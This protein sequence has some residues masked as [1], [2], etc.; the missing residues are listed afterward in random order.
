VKKKKKEKKKKRK[1][2]NKKIIPIK[3]PE[4][5]ELNSE[6]VGGSPSIDSIV[7]NIVYA[8]SLSA[9]CLKEEEKLKRDIENQIIPLNIEKILE[10]YKDAYNTVQIWNNQ[11]ESNHVP[12]YHANKKLTYIFT[13]FLNS[14]N[15]KIHIDSIKE[16]CD[17]YLYQTI[18]SM[19]NN[20]DKFR[21]IVRQISYS[22]KKF[23][24]HILNLINHNNRLLNKDCV[25]CID[26]SN[27]NMH[28]VCLELL[29]SILKTVPQDGFDRKYLACLKKDG[30]DEIYTNLMKCIPFESNTSQILPHTHS[31][32][33]IC[34]AFLTPSENNGLDTSQV[35]IN[36]EK[37]GNNVMPQP[38]KTPLWKIIWHKISEP[39]M[40]FLICFILI[41]VIILAVRQK[42][43]VRDLIGIILTLV[44]VLGTL[45]IGTF[46]D[47]RAE[48]SGSHHVKKEHMVMVR[49]NKGE[50]SQINADDLVVGDVVVGLKE[51]EN[52]PADG[53]VFNVNNFSTMEAMLTG[54]PIEVRKED[55]VLPRDTPLGNRKNMCFAS[56][57]V[58]SGTSDLIVCATGKNTECGSLTEI[59]E[60]TRK[61]NENKKTPL[62]ISIA[63]LSYVLIGLAIIFCCA[64][65]FIGIGLEYPNIEIFEISLSLAASAV[66][67]GLPAILI[68]TITIVASVMKRANCEI[69][70]NSAV[71]TIGSVSRICSDKTGT[72]TVG[73]MSA[74]YED[75]VIVN[76][77]KTFE[78]NMACLFCNS[79]EESKLTGSEVVTEKDGDMTEIAIIQMIQ[80]QT[81]RPSHHYKRKFICPFDSN[82]KRMSCGIQLHDDDDNILVLA[83]GAPESILSFCSNA[84]ET[85]LKSSRNMA[86][87]GIRVLALAY[88]QMP[89]PKSVSDSN[90]L[91]NV[92]ESELIFL[93]L[94]GI[95]DP[96]KEGVK[97]T[98]NELHLAHIPVVMITGDHPDTGQAIAEQLDIFK[99]DENHTTMTGADFIAWNESY[100]NDQTS[101]KER[102]KL[103][104]KFKNV[105]VFA[106]VTP[107]EKRLIVQA[108]QKDRDIV[109]MLGDGPND[110][111]AI[112]EAD[113]GYAMFS[114]TDMAKDNA[115]VVILDNRLNS[116]TDSIRYGRSIFDN[117][118]KFI[119]YLISCNFAEVFV[120]LFFVCLDSKLPLTV[121]M[122]LWANIFADIPPSVA[123]SYELPHPDI[124]QRHP[125][126][127]DKKIVSWSLFIFIFLQS[128]LIS[129]YTCL[130][131]TFVSFAFEYDDYRKRA[132]AYTVL[133]CVQL[134][135]T[136]WCRYP[137]EYIHSFRN[138]VETL[139]GS[140]CVNTSIIISICLLIA[141]LYIP[142][143]NENI[144]ITEL[145][146]KDWLI[147]MCACVIHGIVMQFLKFLYKRAGVNEGHKV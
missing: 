27:V 109:A 51:G 56:T 24:N 83:K 38:Q 147:V 138:L 10:H 110:A 127:K 142:G 91:M 4:E 143:V 131:F 133:S 35:E 48:R 14:K 64:I 144:G 105:R 128:I 141:S 117:V 75:C 30:N 90:E 25:V 130:S 61:E 63:Q 8:L 1:K 68:V 92:A 126:S 107:N 116:L 74:R 17:W 37:Y 59:M 112:V 114:G 79:V 23:E 108:F 31:I 97:Q 78:F 146:W 103:M 22:E 5:I 89:N 82:R 62:M 99:M 95:L 100:N 118:Q 42:H 11:A 145:D 106:R 72:L 119:I 139:T 93:G 70:N 12:T 129:L 80:T 124:M 140:M 40:I 102:K 33:E 58:S 66:P 55:V 86:K 121:N 20:S 101:E 123:I 54:E 113:V 98:V 6:G 2:M 47:Y 120:M 45:I 7:S 52:I 67:E 15:E 77:E 94:V 88:K 32:M 28:T 49:R 29:T 104:D 125:I 85:Y 13:L 137:F 16:Q 87:K 39:M 26:G 96:P 53:R 21:Q 18:T 60:E 135:H 46:Q 9:L 19:L 3:T 50:N 84:N 132:L 134:T 36:R 43:V 115:D 136:W 122:L 111:P 65:F 69:R 71:Q 76:S 81:S 73:K 34:L 57:S 44:L 41:E